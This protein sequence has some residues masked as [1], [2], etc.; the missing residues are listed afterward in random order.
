M[1]KTSL[2]SEV[3]T[4][5]E[6]QVDFLFDNFYKPTP[7]L[8]TLVNI[9]RRHK[10]T[11]LLQQARCLAATLPKPQVRIGSSPCALRRSKGRVA[12]RLRAMNES[13]DLNMYHEAA[14]SEYVVRFSLNEI[15]LTGFLSC[16]LRK[17]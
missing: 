7:V 16:S 2:C 8:S 3:M 12:L 15:P 9:L 14:I 10:M 1:F 4:K 11:L 13:F 6:V 5:F 17:K